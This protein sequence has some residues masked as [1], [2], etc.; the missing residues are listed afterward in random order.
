MSKLSYIIN[1]SLD[2]YIEDATGAFDW[3]NPDRVF[4]CVTELLGSVGTQLLGRRLYET[5]AVW[6]AP[7]ESHPPEHREFARLWQRAEKVVF[8]RTLTGA[9]TRNTRVV[10]DFDIEA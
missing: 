5:M 7:V 10:R 9:T 2:G 8:S 3:V 4:E 6:D 1:T